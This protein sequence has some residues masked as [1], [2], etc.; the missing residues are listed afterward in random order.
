MS[1]ESAAPVAATGADS[2]ELNHSEREV[3]DLI[4]ARYSLIYLISSEEQR[5]EESLLRLARRRDMKLGVWSITRGMVQKFGT[6]KGGDVKDPIKALDYIAAQEGRGLFVLIF[7]GIVIGGSLLL[8]ALRAPDT[9]SNAKPFT[10]GSR[11]TLLLINNLL[12]TCACAM[13]LLG[14]HAWFTHWLVA[15]QLTP[16]AMSMLP[17]EPMNEVQEFWL[18][19]VP[20][21]NTLQKLPLLN[22]AC[23]A[24]LVSPVTG[25]PSS[26]AGPPSMR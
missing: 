12:L 7:L 20:Q 18:L 6:L 8:Y 23:S 5:V 10:A 26:P 17:D 11:E 14:T 24:Q 16:F 19:L 1:Q 21:N 3:L 2:E 13:V 4:R 9:E 22:D 25:K 15:P